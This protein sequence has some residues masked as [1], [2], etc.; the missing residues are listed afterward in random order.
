MQRHMRGGLAVAALVATASCATVGVN[1]TTQS[2][3]VVSTPPGAEVYLDGRSAG[4]T[5]TEL[6]V[7]RRNRAPE[8]RIEKSGFRAHARVMQRQ[9]SW[10]ILGNAG[11]A[12][13][14]VPAV[15]WS[16]LEGDTGPHTFAQ[17]AIPWAVAALPV[18]TDF[19]TGAAF[20]FT[21]RID[22]VLEPVES[23]TLE[24][25]D[26]LRAELSRSLRPRPDPPTMRSTGRPSGLLCRWES[27]CHT[28]R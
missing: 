8:I 28:G 26:G 9:E 23:R 25:P 15:G 10:W 19:L 18:I 3:R 11:F 5:P 27:R 13:I 22:A 17:T 2:V 12:A 6:T 16:L 1:G 4:K 21:P 14:L 24:V 7:S 20:K